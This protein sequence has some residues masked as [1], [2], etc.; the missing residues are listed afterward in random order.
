VRSTRH[1]R[2]RGRFRP[3]FKEPDFNGALLVGKGEAR[4]S[5]RVDLLTKSSK[6]IRENMVLEVDGWA[7]ACPGRSPCR[8]VRRR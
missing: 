6:L 4:F 3:G 8:R 1:V 5:L 7:G 2:R